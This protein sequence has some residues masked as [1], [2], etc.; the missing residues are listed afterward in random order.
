MRSFLNH[1][2]V[3][4]GSSHMINYV[5]DQL[6]LR[7]QTLAAVCV[8]VFCF[9]EKFLLRKKLTL[10]SLPDFVFVTQEVMS[11]FVLIVFPRFE[12]VQHKEKNH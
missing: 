9:T 4:F 7:T 6:I 12:I 10:I 2:N 5:I 3:H 11:L 8:H 1:F